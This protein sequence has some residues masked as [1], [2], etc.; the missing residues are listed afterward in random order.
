MEIVPYRSLGQDEAGGI[1]D[2]IRFSNTKSLSILEQARLIEELKRC[3]QMSVTDIA[4][5]LEKSKSW[6]S[7][8]CGIMGE[9]SET[10][11]KEVFAGKFPVYSFMYTLRRF[12][13]MNSIK[14][15]EIDEFVRSVSGKK[16]SIRDIGLLANGYFKGSDEFR[17][18]I[19]TGNLFWGLERL[20]RNDAIGD[21]LSERE[22][23]ILKTLEITLR[24]MQRFMAQHD[25]GSTSNAFAAQAN[26]LS[27]GMIELFDV[28]KAAMEAF[29]DSTEQ[30]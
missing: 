9:M 5:L 16:L 12:I 22:K 13:R 28:F 20:K 18:Q 4:G 25:A 26:M 8:R 17:A 21:G 2:L 11:K 10:V 19:K 14:K 23:T 6:V 29:H 7:M 15:S 1:I 24:Y 27:G 3:H 30:A